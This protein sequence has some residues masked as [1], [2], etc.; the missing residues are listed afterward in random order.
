M[1]GLCRLVVVSVV[2]LIG[3]TR[4]VKLLVKRGADGGYI[5][6]AVGVIKNVNVSRV[7]LA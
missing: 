4:I 6:V 2:V 7:V 5:G 3:Y 1:L